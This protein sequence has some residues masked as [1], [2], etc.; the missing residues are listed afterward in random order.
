MALLFVWA[1]SSCIFKHFQV[2]K[3]GAWFVQKP[4]QKKK[5]VLT[6]FIFSSPHTGNIDIVQFHYELF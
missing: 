2:L 5:L 6:A 3:T 1:D 4:K